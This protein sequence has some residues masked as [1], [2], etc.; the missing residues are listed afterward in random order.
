MPN[1]TSEA[2]WTVSVARHLAAEHLGGLGRRWSHVQRVGSV[3]EAYLSAGAVDATVPAAA[4]LH[5]IGY[6]PDLAETGFHPVDGARFLKR[7]D[8]PEEIVGLVAYHTGSMFEADERGL[9]ARLETHPRPDSD[10]LDAITLIDL[11]VGPDGQVVAPVD[12]IAEILSRYG[13]STP[14][15]R[16]ISRAESYLLR[17]CARAYDRLGPI[18]PEV[19]QPR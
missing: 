13:S 5:D 6:A 10:N 12:R 9:L 1:R 15:H 3:A 19:F 16:A 8:A 2:Q 11:S 14:V 4:W 17:V 7:R 18:P